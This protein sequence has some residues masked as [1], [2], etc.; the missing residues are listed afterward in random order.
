[1]S[2]QKFAV[3]AALISYIGFSSI[4]CQRHVCADSS[5]MITEAHSSEAFAKSD[6]SKI[7]VREDSGHTYFMSESKLESSL[8]SLSRDNNTNFEDAW[9]FHNGKVI[10][11]GICENHLQVSINIIQLSLELNNSKPGDTL[12]MYHIH[13][14]SYKHNRFSPPSSFDIRTHALIKPY[15]DSRRIVF[16]ERVFDGR[17]CWEFD[18]TSDVINKLND[19]DK[20]K[21]DKF[22]SAINS[23]IDYNCKLAD[24]YGY[25]CTSDNWGTTNSYSL[26]SIAR[27]IKAM[28]NIGLKIKFTRNKFSDYRF[29]TDRF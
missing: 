21:S 28:D 1:M 12:I 4:S 13:P 18:A 8:D 16:I 29:V 25:W 3:A 20:K 24:P 14:D 2:V 17:G 19:M 27:Y 15:L 7:S 22:Y 23:S 9:V 26:A 5:K 10:D 6:S 11:A